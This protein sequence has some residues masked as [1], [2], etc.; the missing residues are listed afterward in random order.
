MS[1]IDYHIFL[2]HSSADRIEVVRL[3]DE[4]EHESFKVWISCDD[5]PEGI[6]FDGRIQNEMDRSAV[7]LVVRHVSD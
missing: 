6:T 4:L 7:M 2:S 1:N 5:I 3:K